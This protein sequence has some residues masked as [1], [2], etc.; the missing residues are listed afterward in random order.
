MRS[1]E[2]WVPTGS[3]TTPD[4]RIPRR[5]GVAKYVIEFNA[6]VAAEDGIAPGAMICGITRLR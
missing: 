5:D 2:S 3:T 6:S 4:D 1:V